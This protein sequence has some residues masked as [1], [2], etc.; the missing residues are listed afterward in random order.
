M[1]KYVDL[2]LAIWT[3]LIA[4]GLASVAIKWAIANTKNK[5]ILMFEKWALQAVNYA[6]RNSDTSEA[7]KSQ[8]ISFVTDEL[9]KNNLI[10][11][12]SNEQI[13]AVIEKS[14]AD[15]HDWKPE[16]KNLP[17]PVPEDTSKSETVNDTTEV[18]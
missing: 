7:K 17:V 5:N 1:S 10:K 2:I 16:I 14:V 11:K 9:R 15:L 4:T 18:K 13:D 12:F 3:I 6:E 8:A